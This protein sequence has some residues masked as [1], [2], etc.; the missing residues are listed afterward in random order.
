M[1]APPAKI[2]RLRENDAPWLRPPAP[3]GHDGP[4]EDRLLRKEVERFGLIGM[5]NELL[6]DEIEPSARPIRNPQVPLG[7]DVRIKGHHLFPPR[8]SAIKYSIK[9]MLG[10]HAAA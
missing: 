5:F 1:S 9:T 10:V 4:L 6:L 3:P 8:G 7:V 2:V